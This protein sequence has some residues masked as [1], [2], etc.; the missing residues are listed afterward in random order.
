[1][2][3][4]SELLWKAADIQIT[5]Q[6]EE[7]RGNVGWNCASHII[8]FH[9]FL[10]CFVFLSHQ[11]IVVFFHSDINHKFAY[12]ASIVCLKNIIHNS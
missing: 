3:P 1:M 10:F 12:N 2:L 7:A 8:Y 4:L 9:V 6:L 11:N 5:Q